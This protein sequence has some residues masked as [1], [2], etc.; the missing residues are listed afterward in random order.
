MGV[1]SVLSR[2]GQLDPAVLVVNSIGQPQFEASRLRELAAGLP[3]LRAI[4]VMDDSPLP[5]DLPVPVHRAAGPAADEA[6]WERYPFNHPLFALFSSGTTGRPKCIVHGAGGT[7]L[8]HLKEHVLHG[9]LRAGEKLF[10]HTSTAWMMW[11]WQLS[12]L[13][14]GAEILLYHGPVIEPETLWRIAAE[15]RVTVFGTSPAY[16][17]L[18][19]RAGYAPRRRLDLGSLRAVMSTGAIVYDDQFEWF[20]SDSGRFRSSRSRAER[21]SSAASCSATRPCP[22]MPARRSAGAS[23]STSGRSG[24]TS[25]ASATWS[26][27]RRSRP[28]RWGSTTTRRGSGSTPRTSPS[29]RM[30]GRTAT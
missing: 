22:S 29:T 24:R 17:R 12:A 10:F 7:L 27:R 9:D 26:A 18:C 19:E 25:R 20:A 16:L 15:E 5:S 3:T 1:G 4:V 2:F 21:T 23:A 11:N 8:E 13:A 28:G 6:A 30:S 14:C